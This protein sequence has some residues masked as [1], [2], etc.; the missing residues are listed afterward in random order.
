MPAGSPMSKARLT[1]RPSLHRGKIVTVGPARGSSSAHRSIWPGLEGF[2]HHRAFAEI[3]EADL[4]EI[5]A[6]AVH[7]EILA[8]VVGVALERDG[9]AGIDLARRDKGPS[10]SAAHRGWYP[11]S[12]RRSMGCFGSTGI[13]PRI[14]GSLAV[15]AASKVKRTSRSP[16][17][18]ALHD[19][20]EEVRWFGRPFALSRLNENSTSAAVIGLPSENCAAGLRWKVIESRSS[21]ISIVSAM[22]P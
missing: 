19:L 2:E 15:A 14:S 10:R 7:G 1:T 5:E 18:L 9:A 17:P 13:S 22:R 11:Q 6:A 3:V 21:G 8:P 12:D 4:I 20:G 16:T